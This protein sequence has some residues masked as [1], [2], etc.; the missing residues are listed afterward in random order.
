VPV[1]D[2]L[3][4]VLAPPPV[5]QVG[6]VGDTH[7]EDEPGVLDRPLVVV[8]DHPRVGD[9]G[10]L[11]QSVGGHERLQH[12]QH[13]LGLG[14][15]ALERVHHQREPG[16]VGQQPDGDLRVQAPLLGEPRLTE[17]VTGVGLEVQR[18]DTS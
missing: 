12:R 8:G 14:P 10:H 1:G 11:G 6:H 7:A 16:R 17:P 15:V 3:A 13:G 5:H 2:V 9:H 4:G 18:T